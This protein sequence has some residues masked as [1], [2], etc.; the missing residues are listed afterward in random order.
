MDLPHN[1]QSRLLG[2]N[3]ED[4]EFSFLLFWHSVLNK[5]VRNLKISHRVTT[6]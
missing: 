3:I 1:C 4:M 6:Y 5:V 2:L